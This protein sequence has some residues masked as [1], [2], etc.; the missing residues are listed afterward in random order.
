[1]S[2]FLNSL[3]TSKQEDAAK[4]K[5]KVIFANGMTSVVLKNH[6]LQDTYRPFNETY[7]RLCVSLFVY[8]S[9]TTHHTDSRLMICNECHPKK[10]THSLEPFQMLSVRVCGFIFPPSVVLLG[11]FS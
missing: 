11:G 1:M 10:V 2:W 9:K 4:V 7:A 5:T 3:S 8:K 6:R